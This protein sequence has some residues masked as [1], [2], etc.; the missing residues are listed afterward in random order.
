MSPFSHLRIPMLYP[1][2]IHLHASLRMTEAPVEEPETIPEAPASPQPNKP[3][4]A[5]DTDPFNPSW[6]DDRPEPQP[7]AFR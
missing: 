3:A 1:N 6:P 2:S 4:P 5:P 7:K